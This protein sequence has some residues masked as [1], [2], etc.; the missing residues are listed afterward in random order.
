MV[1]ERTPSELGSYSKRKGDE[2]ERHICKL[3]KKILEIDARRTPS[4][5]ALF[6]KSDITGFIANTFMRNWFFEKYFIEC[7]NRDNV[8]VVKWFGTAEQK[9][10]IGARQ[11]VILFWRSKEPIDFITMRAEDFLY[12]MSELQE[13]TDRRERK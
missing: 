13:L 2:Y 11:N 1:K 5:G 12:I 10:S 8:S 7:K 4:S 6:I 3:I 9:V